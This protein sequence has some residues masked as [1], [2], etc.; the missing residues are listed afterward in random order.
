MRVA[1]RMGTNSPS[2]KAAICPDWP[3]LFHVSIEAVWSLLNFNTFKNQ[4]SH[5]QT[6]TKCVSS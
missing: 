1:D 5:F 2:A 3:Q 4:S 6:S